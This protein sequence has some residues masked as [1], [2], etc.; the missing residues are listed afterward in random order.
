MPVFCADIGQSDQV[1]RIG[2]QIVRVLAQQPLNLGV[3]IAGDVEKRRGSRFID[4]PD[5]RRP[6]VEM[7][8]VRRHRHA[9][10]FPADCGQLAPER[11]LVPGDF[12]QDERAPE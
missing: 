4:D 6:P 5:R 8:P 1:G 3:G 2:Y 9:L 7:E 11:A 10:F 12:P